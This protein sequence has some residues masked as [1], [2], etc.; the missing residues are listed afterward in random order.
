M[1]RA[2]TL[3]VG[4]ATALLPTGCGQATGPFVAGS[5]STPLTCLQH[6]KYAPGG[7]ATKST[8][9]GLEVLRYY[10]ANGGR[11]YCDGKKPT[12]RDRAWARVYVK[13]GAKPEYV[14]GI[15]GKP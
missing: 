10:T 9:Y 13:L 11:P 6:Q 4:A 2:L 1:I 5:G 12:S 7:E 8:V 15:L 14:Q 3:F